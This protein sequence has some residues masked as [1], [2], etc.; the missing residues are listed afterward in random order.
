M[1]F[2]NIYEEKKKKMIGI[3]EEGLKFSSLVNPVL[4]D[5]NYEI[6]LSEEESL[7]YINHIKE[8]IKGEYEAMKWMLPQIKNGIN[9]REALNKVIEKEYKKAWG[10]DTTEAVI[11]TQR[12]G[13]IARMFELGLIEKEKD[14]I[15]VKYVVS[16]LGNQTFEF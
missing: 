12:A 13:L 4:D 5:N 6:A 3:T 11:N 9:D 2:C 7:F 14:G 16:N 10:N 15:R 1:R 8:N